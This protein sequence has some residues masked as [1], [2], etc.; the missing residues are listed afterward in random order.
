M[1]WEMGVVGGYASV[2]APVVGAMSDLLGDSP[3]G[4]TE[5]SQLLLPSRLFFFLSSFLPFVIKGTSKLEA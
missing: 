2:S 4:T 5:K 1:A 3:H